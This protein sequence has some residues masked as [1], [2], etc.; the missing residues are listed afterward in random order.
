MRDVSRRA[1]EAE[2]LDEEG[3]DP[4][5]L[6]HSLGQ[7][8][9]VN[10]WF[11]GSRALRRH[12]RPL[13]DPGRPVRL[14]D[15]GTGNGETLDD[16]LSWARA[17][18]GRWTGVGV[19]RS[20]AVAR[21]AARDARAPTIRGDA[22][23]LPFATGS[24]DVAVCTLTL[25]HFPEEPAV[26]LLREMRRV[27]RELVL[28]NDLERHALAH[29]SARLLARTLWR[30]NRITRHDGPLSV[31]RSFTPEELLALGR[32]AGLHDATVHRHFPWRLVLAGGGGVGPS[33]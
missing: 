15:V 6:A 20:A 25:H 14:L 21:I 31:L 18:G 10:R 28:V 5:E 33:E 12:L 26:R 27:A 22:L 32:S 13:L 29:L 7:V 3:H 1:Y 30:G 17:R 19:D 8:A 16:I 24:V 9:R 2:L 4:E 11:G 23:A